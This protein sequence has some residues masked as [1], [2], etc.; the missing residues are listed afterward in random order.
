MPDIPYIV[1]RSLRTRSVRLS[2]YPDGRVV[3][4]APRFVSLRTL[5]QFVETKTS[6][7]IE[8]TKTFQSSGPPRVSPRE[9]RKNYLEHKEAA[10]RFIHERLVYLNRPYGFVYRKIFIKDQKTCWG[11]CS[12]K[13]NLNFSYRLLFLP[14]H[15]ADYVLVHELCHLKEM[16]H[17]KRFWSYVAQTFPQYQKLRR[18]L[19]EQARLLR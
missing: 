18:E 9:A 12:K 2:V 10:R 1:R 4:S 19:R 3:V 16:N 15:L 6:W 14:P 17:G 13:G 7:I 8:K 11:S 5:K